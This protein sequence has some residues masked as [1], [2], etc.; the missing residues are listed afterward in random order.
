MS[1]ECSWAH[2]DRDKSVFLSIRELLI[3]I[4]DTFHVN[5][6]RPACLPLHFISEI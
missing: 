4:V 2:E 6:I 5:L 3:N 1:G